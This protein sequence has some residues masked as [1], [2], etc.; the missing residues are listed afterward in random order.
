A[1]LL[2]GK[3]LELTLE[4]SPAL[5]ALEVERAARECR[6]HRAAGLPAVRAVVEPAVRRER[7][8]VLEGGLEARLRVPELQ[9]SHAGRVEHQPAVRKRHEL[10]ARGR[11]PAAAVLAHLA[12]CQQLVAYERVHQRRLADAGRPEQRRRPSVR[13]VG[14]Y[15][16]DA[17]AVRC[18]HGVHGNTEGDRL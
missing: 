6:A 16:L 8:D 7:L 13:D 15:G 18:A 17:V 4:L 10:A 3:P 9:L 12:R 14:A 2:A 5:E 11:V 1:I